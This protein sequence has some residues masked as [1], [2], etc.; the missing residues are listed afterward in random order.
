MSMSNSCLLNIHYWMFTFEWKLENCFEKV[1]IYFEIFFL[2]FSFSTGFF[3]LPSWIEIFHAALDGA[4]TY[5]SA[6]VCYWRK[7][8]KLFFTSFLFRCSFP[9]FTHGLESF[10]TVGLYCYSIFISMQSF[11]ACW[12]NLCFVKAQFSYLKQILKISRI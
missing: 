3:D 2:F 10:P 7:S 12:F 5:V 4:C 11:K 9:S 8:S 6:D 1:L